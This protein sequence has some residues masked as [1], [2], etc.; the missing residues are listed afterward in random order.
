MKILQITN[1]V[2]YPPKDGGSVAVLNLGQGLAQQ[3]H[4]MHMLAINTSRHHVPKASLKNGIPGY[5]SVRTVYLDTSIRTGEALTN[6]F[7]SHKPYN[8]VRFKGDSVLGALRKFLQDFAFDVII[9]EGLYLTPYLETI[10]NHS[11][12]LLVYRAHNIE[13]EIWQRAALREN[14]PL[15]R[16]YYYITARRLRRIEKLY[17]N[18]YDTL[19]PITN[20]DYQVYRQLGNSKPAR[21]S[22]T[23]ITASAFSAYNTQKNQVG[24]FYLGALDWFPNQEGLIW[25]I[26]KVWP[27]FYSKYPDT[28]FFI[29]GRN[30]PAW[31]KR[32]CTKTGIKFYGEVN[33]A[34]DFMVRRK[35]MV[36]PLFSGSGM[37]I[38]IIE[39]MAAG[40]V[41]ITTSIGAEG[42]P[43][44]NG[45]ELF[46]ADKEADFLE[47]LEMLIN[48][49]ELRRRIGEQAR[50]FVEKR[51]DNRVISEDLSNFLKEQIA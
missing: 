48:D 19:V 42:I 35:I 31:L 26:K 28:S 1:K 37:R 27:Q 2:P 8:Y 22:S 13:Y 39:G 11:R 43:V 21:V 34:I 40:R 12:A 23:G 44:T 14:N 33:D 51:F 3:N 16:V 5:S 24:I 32:F 9:L 45:K 18:R 20:R 15:R 49:K 17:I 36:V 7:L 29:G 50:E 41:I 4:E 25:F 10:R 47:I 30:A 6:L 46:I 38:K